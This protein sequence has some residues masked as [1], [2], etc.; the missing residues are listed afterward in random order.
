M[1]SS[2]SLIPWIGRLAALIMLA[3][4]AWLGASIF[5]SLTAPQ[6][7]RPSPQMETDPQTATQSIASRHLF[8]AAL[9]A[10]AI[11]SAPVDIRLSG[12]IAAQHQGER[13][14]ALLAIEGKS[15]Q[16]VREGE[17]VAPGV[18]LQRVLPR[19]VELLRGGR[20][21]LPTLPERGKS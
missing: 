9:S 17:E 15:P 20:T 8:G 3:V 13:A 21:Q 11:A 19:Q 10:T 16:I 1:L 6:S 5:W 2:A 12:T 4:M 7:T 14:F 18:I